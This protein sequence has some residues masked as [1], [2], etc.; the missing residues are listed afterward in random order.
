MNS[1]KSVGTLVERGETVSLEMC[2][3]AEKEKENMSR[4]PYS[5]VFGSL[6]ML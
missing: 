6:I 1:C 2:P 3:N 4:F 5:R